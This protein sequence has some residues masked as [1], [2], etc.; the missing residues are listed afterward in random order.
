MSFDAFFNAYLETALWSSTDDRD[1]PLDKRF[2]V[3]DFTADSRVKLFRMARGFWMANEDMIADE[4]EKAGH[5]LWLTQNGHGA[6]FWDGDW[7]E[8]QASALDRAAKSLGEVH[9]N[10]YRK[11]IV[12]DL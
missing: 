11:K 1:Q 7:P 4:P 9:L 10:V 8:P 12:V 3:R 2:G 5:D 6:G